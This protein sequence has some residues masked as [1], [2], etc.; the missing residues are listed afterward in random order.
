MVDLDAIKQLSFPAGEWCV[1]GGAAMELLG[2]R[3]NTRDVDLLV[4]DAVYRLLMTSRRH[5][6][7]L[8]WIFNDEGSCGFVDPGTLVLADSHPIIE[9][10]SP[11]TWLD[12]AV[13]LDWIREAEMI[14]GVPVIRADHLLAWKEATGREKD[15]ADAA[16]VRCY[17]DNRCQ[18]PNCGHV[19]H[20]ATPTGEKQVARGLPRVLRREI[21]R[22]TNN[23]WPF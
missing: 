16:A 4:T 18:C 21:V 8:K 17:L 11:T 7:G 23:D 6:R 13:K 2:I 1:C 9:L 19:W 10:L 12:S 20:K 3:E 15:K 5:W 14:Q 22:N